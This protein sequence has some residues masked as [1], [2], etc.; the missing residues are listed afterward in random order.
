MFIASVAIT[1]ETTLTTQS[2]SRRL[3]AFYAIKFYAQRRDKMYTL[4]YQHTLTR[5]LIRWTN[6]GAEPFFRR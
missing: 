6:Y 5:S 4:Y 3:L 1:S 2:L